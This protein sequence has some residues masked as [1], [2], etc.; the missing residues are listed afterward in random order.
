[1]VNDQSLSNISCK[2]KIFEKSNFID[3]NEIYNN[4]MMK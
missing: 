4:E 3:I 1:M 2:G